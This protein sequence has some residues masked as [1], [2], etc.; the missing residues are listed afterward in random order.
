[1]EQELAE[2]QRCSRPLGHARV[3]GL[4]ERGARRDGAASVMS[5][6]RCPVPGPA[7]RNRGPLFL[8]GR[9]SK[10]R[11]DGTSEADELP[12]ERDW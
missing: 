11:V 8:R 5:H 3:P 4:G 1:M 7:D 10:K 6:S 2:I 12:R 9:Q